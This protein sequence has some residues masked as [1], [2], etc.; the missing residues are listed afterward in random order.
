MRNIRN[1]MRRD[2][3]SLPISI[4]ANN[5]SLD[6]SFA[7]HVPCG[8]LSCTVSKEALI[9]D[10]DL[11]N[12]RTS[13]LVLSTRDTEG[14]IIYFYVFS[15]VVPGPQNLDNSDGKRRTHFS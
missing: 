14:T 11:D 12:S 9:C 7:E 3:K 4:R 8:W 15:R 13:N 1:A 5:F 6:D 10:P 2:G